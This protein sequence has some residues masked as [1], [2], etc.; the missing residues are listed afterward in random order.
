AALRAGKHVLCEKP[1]VVNPQELED[2]ISVA[3]ETGKYFMEGM[4]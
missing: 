3:Q 4:W 1:V 2:V